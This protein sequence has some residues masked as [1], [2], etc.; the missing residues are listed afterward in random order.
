MLV[1][2]A[3]NLING[4][5]YIGATTKSLENRRKG[6]INHAYGSAKNGY[7]QDAI[8]KYGPDSFNFEEIDEADTLDE[9]YKKEQYWIKYYNS[10]DDRYG[11]NLDSGGIYCKKSESTKRK[12]GDTTLQKWKNPDISSRMLGGLRKGTEKWKEIC[13]YKRIEF[14]CPICGKTMYLPAYIAKNKRYCSRECE[15][16]SGEYYARAKYA[17]DI[18]AVM[19]HERNLDRK[20]DIA[21]DILDWAF[22]NR[23]YVMSCKFNDITNHYKP[24]TDYLYEKYGIFDLRSIYICFD[25]RNKREFAQSLINIVSEENIC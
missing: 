3:T 24:L 14:T 18:A 11:Y 1:Y 2:K 23:E 17:S 25:V 6:H 22:A 5:V 15:I 20:R 12:I 16:E 8:L 7:F 19:S 4:K 21:E 9:M 13:R 10:T